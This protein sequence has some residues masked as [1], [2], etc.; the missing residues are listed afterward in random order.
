M[1][2]RG[3]SATS[4]S[5]S[6]ATRDALDRLVDGADVVTYEFENVPVEAARAGRRRAGGGGARARAGPAAGEGALPLARDPHRALRHVLRGDGAPGHRQV[7]A[8]RLRRQGTASRSRAR[9]AWG[10]TRSRRSSSRSIVSSRSSVSAG[11]TA[12]RGSGPLGE[13]VHRD[14]ILRVTRAPAANAPQ[15]EAETICTAF[16]DALDYV[17]VLAVELFDVGGRLLANEFAPR[18]HNTAH[19]TIDGAETS[20]FENHLRAILGLPL[21][22]TEARAQMRDGQP[23]RDAASA[24]GAARG[25]RCAGAPV[26][27]GA[28]PGTEGGARHASRPDRRD[29]RPGDR[30]DRLL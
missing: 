25:A 7:E 23:D 20:Q 9:D 27:Q 28:A 1:R 21:G 13:N 4:S 16:M 10:T 3:R 19:W 24:R 18:V 8:A 11:G 14:G 12:R 17:G 29:R 26:R 30:A 15:A 5:A 2:A 6:T 22:S